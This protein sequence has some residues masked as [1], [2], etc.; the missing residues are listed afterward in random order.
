MRYSPLFKKKILLVRIFVP[1]FTLFLTQSEAS[2]YP[3]QVV[4]EIL[5]Y[6]VEHRAISPLIVRRLFKLYL[7]QFDLNKT[8][9]LKKEV[10]QLH[11]LEDNHVW[12]V[13]YR[14]RK[15]DLSD[16]FDIH[17]LMDQ[18]ITRSQEMRKELALQFIESESID[19]KE[20][21]SRF[22]FD[23]ADSLSDL[24]RRNYIELC[25]FARQYGKTTDLTPEIKQKII[26]LWQKRKENREKKYQFAMQSEIEKK[27]N[28]GDCFL[29]AFANSLD[30]H[31]AFY[32]EKEAHE[33]RTTLK[34]QLEGIGVIIKEGIHGIYISY[35]FNGSPAS[36]SILQKGD[37]ITAIN[38]ESMLHVP[39]EKVAEM[40]Q[41]PAR[42]SMTLTVLR[43]KEDE[44]EVIT[45]PLQRERITLEEERVSHK[46]SPCGDG[47]IGKITLPSFY[48][49]GDGVTAEQDL[50]EAIK[51][52]KKEGK[53]QGLIIDVRENSGGFLSEAIKVSKLFIPKGIIVISKYAGNEIRYVRDIDGRILYDGP[54]IM[55]TS[56]ASASAAEIVAQVLQDYGIVIV[57]GDIR[58][59]G[60][61]SI[62]YQT[63]TEE[64]SKA[65]YK[66]TVGKYYTASGK[67]TQLEGVKADIHVPTK[68]APFPIGERY[69]EFA[70]PGDHMD[71]S[72]FDILKE[73]DPGKYRNFQ[74]E[75]FPL[76]PGVESK[77]QKMRPTLRQNS[78]ARVHQYNMKLDAKQIKQQD[79]AAIESEEILR[80][81]IFLDSQN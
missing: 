65:F 50:K 57:V 69:L 60:K 5:N 26:N 23:Y 68:F 58:T 81:M 19:T 55:L 62:Q 54:I 3:S 76:L 25:L 35:L 63:I 15:G 59:Y 21:D 41:G 34:K 48:D 13:I 2:D 12:Q 66:V 78:A 9:F 33:I 75:F 72:Y 43:M 38:G 40:M 10:A 64:N 16:F 4:Q 46:S 56:K 61:G 77:W 47:I 27:K 14:L 7:S 70:L 80:D 74:E 36:R 20:I 71:F 24:K 22:F 53:L 51:S 52:L 8:Y 11:R 32:T 49:S 31:S 28:I 17:I 30:A 44:K 39:F 6:H 18:A 37:Y 67:S 45:V 73:T 42:S 79:I 29:K 1:I